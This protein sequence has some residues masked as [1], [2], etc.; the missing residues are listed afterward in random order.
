MKQLEKGER[1]EE[2]F[3]FYQIK[4]GM[5]SGHP[6]GLFSGWLEILGVRFKRKTIRDKAVN[7]RS[8]STK[9]IFKTREQY[10]HVCKE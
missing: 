1:E 3:V 7:F 8:H 9:A 6:G 4:L 5:L 10:Y 2:W